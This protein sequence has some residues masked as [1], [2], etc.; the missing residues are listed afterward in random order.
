MYKALECNIST[1][2]CAF[3]HYL[4]DVN[5][6]KPVQQSENFVQM[7]VC[8]YLKRVCSRYKLL[9][10]R[11]C[12]YWSSCRYK[13]YIYMHSLV[14]YGHETCSVILREEHGLRVIEDRAR[15]RIFGP[16]RMK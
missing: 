1:V 4:V 6:R 11:I 12:C 10:L 13:Q 2:L 16:N 7:S 9:L 14:P 3:P 15:R 5:S 8:S